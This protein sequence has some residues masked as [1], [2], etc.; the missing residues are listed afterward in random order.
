MQG[1]GGSLVQRDGDGSCPGV[2]PVQGR[3]M[4]VLSRLGWSCPGG[5]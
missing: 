1:V 4:V 3:G 2:G 5:G